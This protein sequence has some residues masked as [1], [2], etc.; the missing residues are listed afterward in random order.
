MH[1]NLLVPILLQLSYVWIIRAAPANVVGHAQRIG[2]RERIVDYIALP[3]PTL[4]FKL[5]RAH[6]PRVGTRE[7]SLHRRV[8]SRLS[9]LQSR[10]AIMLVARELLPRAVARVALLR[11]ASTDS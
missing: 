4:R 8:V 6:H 1:R 3:V 11:R 2:E 5:I 9:K 7:S 10:F